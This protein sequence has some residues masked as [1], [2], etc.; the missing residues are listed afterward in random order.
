VGSYRGGCHY[1]FVV[2]LSVV[3]FHGTK[4]RTVNEIFDQSGM[5]LQRGP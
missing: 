5:H 1:Y 4:F 3:N 2:L